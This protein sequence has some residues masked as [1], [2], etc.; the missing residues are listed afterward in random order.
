MCSSY[1]Y[2]IMLII[3]YCFKFNFSGQLRSYGVHDPSGAVLGYLISGSPFVV[4]NLWDVTDK[5]IDKFSLNCMARIFPPLPPSVMSEMGIEA[6]LLE[7]NENVTGN[8]KN[9]LA[10]SLSAS[11]EVCKLKN[12]VGCAPVLYGIPLRLEL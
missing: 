6:S 11:R 12:I 4:G 7:P 8:D 3:F 2:S 5:D 9:D 10:S 1:L